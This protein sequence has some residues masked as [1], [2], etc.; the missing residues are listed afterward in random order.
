MTTPI[1]RC[2]LPA[3]RQSL[4][5]R[6]TARVACVFRIFLVVPGTSSAIPD[7]FVSHRPLRRHFKL[8]SVIPSV[9]VAV[10]DSLA[11]ITASRAVF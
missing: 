1:E 9:G 11:E 8:F 10:L 5:R 6:H 4:H 7:F 2:C 3:G